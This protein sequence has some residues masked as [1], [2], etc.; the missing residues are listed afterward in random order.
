[1]VE[2]CAATAAEVEVVELEIV[3]VVDATCE[4]VVAVCRIGDTWMIFDEDV[5]MLEV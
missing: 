5:V 2:L 3:V 1:M 4:D